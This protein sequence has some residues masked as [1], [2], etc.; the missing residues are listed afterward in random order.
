MISLKPR[1]TMNTRHINATKLDSDLQKLNPVCLDILAQHCLTTSAQIRPFIFP[2]ISSILAPLNC[3][4]IEPALDVLEDAVRAKKEIVVYR[5]YDVDGICA[6][7]TTSECLGGLGARVHHYANDRSIDGFGICKNGINRILQRWPET[8][9]ILTVDNGIAG[10]E[11]IEYANQRGLSVVV[12]DH[13]EP[14]ESLPPAHAVIDLKRS[15]EVYPFQEMCGTGVAFRLMLDLYRRMNRDITNV[16]STLDL[17]ALATVADVVPL[18]GE[19]RVFVQQGLKSI[20]S[21][22]RPFFRHMLR[23]FDVK[24]INAHYTL[25]F[26][27]APALNSLSRMGE[28]TDFAVEALISQDD[29]WVELQCNAFMELNKARK[30]LTASCLDKAQSEIGDTPDS[31]IISYSDDLREGIVGIIAGRLKEEYWRPALVFAR[32][33]DGVLKGSGRSVDGFDLKEALD[34]CADLLLNYGGHK[35]AV[36]LSLLPEHLSEF[37]NRICTLAAD[38][39]LPPKEIELSSLLDQGNSI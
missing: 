13:H 3:K 29:A 39:Q 15:D 34:Q 8:K 37:K 1:Y 24:I 22:K 26:R 14:N 20:E 32:N 28:D 18:V 7:A 23:L 36:G 27:I 21:A 31:V 9:V 33:E 16:L 12:T 11:A 6:G 25:A 38:I 19:N 4:D 17:V 5:D 2:P 30:E 35:K 10:N